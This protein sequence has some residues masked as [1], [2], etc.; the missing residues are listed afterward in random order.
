M[1]RY[2]VEA[3][4][5]LETTYPELHGRI[6]GGHYP[7]PAYATLI[8]S[9]VSYLWTFGIVLI[10]GGSAIFKFLGMPEP[11]LSVWVSNNKGSTFLALFVLNNI[12]NSLVATGAFE[13]YLDGEVIY[14]KLTSGRFP[15]AADLL[16]ALQAR[17]LHA[18]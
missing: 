15:G 9:A 4:K 7:P 3:Q 12:A 18:A 13:V 14:S 1:Q 16:S 10:I 2:F 5:F 8:A 11:E 6:S 17:G